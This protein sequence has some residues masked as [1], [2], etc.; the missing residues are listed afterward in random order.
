MGENV[1]NVKKMEIN[2][3]VNLKKNLLKWFI[4]FLILNIFR[5]KY[6]N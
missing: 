5:I 2:K 3:N 1:K 6:Y 4:L